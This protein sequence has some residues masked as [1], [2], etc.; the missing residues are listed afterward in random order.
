MLRSTV[1]HWIELLEALHSDLSVV[2]PDIYVL[3]SLLQE[4]RYFK[5]RGVTR[6]VTTLEILLFS[7]AR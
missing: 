1:S 7:E 2:I 5:F 6:S 4:G 3:P